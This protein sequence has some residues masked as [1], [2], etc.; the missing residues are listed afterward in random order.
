M[1]ARMCSV[2]R[3]KQVAPLDIAAL[4]H[5]GHI[6][7]DSDKERH[8]AITLARFPETVARVLKDLYDAA[9]WGN[10]IKKKSERRKGEKRC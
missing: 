2:F 4:R 8:L 9:C 6:A 10:K 5:A 7:L 1:Y 3:Q